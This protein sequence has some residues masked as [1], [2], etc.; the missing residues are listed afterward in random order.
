M[1]YKFHVLR[2]FPMISNEISETWKRSNQLY[3]HNRRSDVVCSEYTHVQSE[4]VVFFHSKS[5]QKIKQKAWRI[6]QNL[7]FFFL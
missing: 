3:Y 6:F 7:I 5:S 2:K 4:S 1:F